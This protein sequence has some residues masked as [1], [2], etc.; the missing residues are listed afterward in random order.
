MPSTQ[1][2]APRPVGGRAALIFAVLSILVFAGTAGWLWFSTPDTVASHFDA[3]GRVDD[4]SS[5]AATMG[6]LV[7]LGIGVPVLFSIRWIWQK[8]PPALISL[9]F[10]DYWLDRGER[11]FVDDC[12][13]EFMRIM[14]GATALL[15]TT[16]L[17]MIMRDARGATMPTAMSFVPTIVFLVVTAAALF[18]TV[19]RLRPPR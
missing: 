10:K 17:V 3:A 7:P 2:P 4:R 6:L 9:P 19:R 1:P 8:L 12:L 15:M 13:M 16:V 18:N 11:T 5:K 14:A